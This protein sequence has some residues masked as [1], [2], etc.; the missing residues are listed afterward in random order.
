MPLDIKEIQHCVSAIEVDNGVHMY[1]QSS[2]CDRPPCQI[3]ICS[4]AL[5]FKYLLSTSWFPATEMSF[6]T[7]ERCQIRG[8]MD[9]LLK[10]GNRCEV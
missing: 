4:L 6:G 9:D 1:F 7:G 2:C 10:G 8:K 5:L 3:P